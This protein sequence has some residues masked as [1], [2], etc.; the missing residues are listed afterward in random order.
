MWCTP[1]LGGEGSAIVSHLQSSLLSVMKESKQLAYQ[2]RYQKLESVVK[3]SHD[4][5]SVMR[6]AVGKHWKTLTDDQKAHL[7]M[8]FTQLSIATY[9]GRFDGY[10]GETFTVISEKTT[11]RGR[12]LVETQLTKAD[13]KPV[14]FNYLLHHSHGEWRIINIIVDGVSDLALKRAE[15]SNI[16]KTKGFSSLVAMLEKQ[17]HKYASDQ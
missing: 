9:A 6:L 13:G 5:P 16:L 10:S 15:Y 2:G 8:T 12:F 7:L 14:R 11:P 3:N 4:L 17:I 1:V